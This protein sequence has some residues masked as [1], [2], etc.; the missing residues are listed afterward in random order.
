MA[1]NLL[2]NISERRVRDPKS[3]ART[4]GLSSTPLDEVPLENARVLRQETL[5]HP[6]VVGK[7]EKHD[8]MIDGTH[9]P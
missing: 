5:A 8:E 2:G 4:V 3:T 9:A 6:A 1:N 7:R